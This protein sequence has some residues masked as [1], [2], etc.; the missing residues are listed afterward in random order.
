NVI[1]N[2]AARGTQLYEG[3]QALMAKHNII[4]DVRGGHGLMTA[5]EMVSDRE[6]KA[7]IDGPTAAT[8]QEVTYQNGAMVRV[9]GPNLILSPPLILTEDEASKI[10]SAL[11]AGFLA[12]RGA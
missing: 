10:L 8:V 6:T 1:E 12:V 7:P 3:C 4:G 2:A 11:D 9:S 5:I